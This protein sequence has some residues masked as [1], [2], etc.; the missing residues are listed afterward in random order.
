[1]KIRKIVKVNKNIG[2]RFWISFFFHYLIVRI[3]KGNKI[4]ETPQGVQE[5]IAQQQAHAVLGEQRL[6]RKQWKNRHAPGCFAGRS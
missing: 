6:G 3:V 1:M 5:I 2:T 4:I